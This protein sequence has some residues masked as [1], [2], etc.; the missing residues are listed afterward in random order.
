M[1]NSVDVNGVRCRRAAV[2]VSSAWGPLRRGF[3]REVGPGRA[4]GAD[5]GGALGFF[6]LS[7][8]FG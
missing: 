7:A 8:G 1:F 5:G 2:L 3:V 4:V 6:F